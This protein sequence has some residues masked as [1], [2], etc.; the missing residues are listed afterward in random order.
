MQKSPFDTERP[1]RTRKSEQSSHPIIA[2]CCEETTKVE[3]KA[4]GPGYVPG[5]QKN[6]LWQ[7]LFAS[8]HEDRSQ[9]H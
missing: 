3:T 1:S 8:S 6:Y 5:V 2:R 7:I 4:S 9:R